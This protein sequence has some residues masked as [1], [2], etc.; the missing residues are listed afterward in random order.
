M[1][2]Q[3]EY[4]IKSLCLPKVGRKTAFKLFNNLSFNLSNDNDWIDFITEQSPLLRLPEYASNDFDMAL[5]KYDNIQSKSEKANIKCISFYD[6]DYP[7]L[8]KS[9]PDS[10]II[11][12]YVGDYSI[13]NTMPTLAIIGTRE[14]SEFGYQS[15]IR[16]SE[17]FTGFGFNIISGL[18][19]GCDTAG[20]KG[21][22]NKNGK[23][24]AVLAH[25]LDKIYPKDNKAL[26]QQIVDNGGLLISEY[27]VEQSPLANYF[28]ERDRI[29]AGLSLGIFVV[30]TDIKGGTMHTVKFATE[31][32]RIVSAL[33][34]PVD[35]LNH[36]KTN[37]N[38]FLIKEKKAIPIGN[39][40]DI[41]FLKNSLMER[42]NGLNTS[43]NTIQNNP[44]IVPPVNEKPIIKEN[45][46]K[47]SQPTLWD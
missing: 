46:N 26:A 3:T 28:V 37:G 47:P 39:P 12:N 15:G 41:E 21:C 2:I 27:F 24:T 31:A 32:N 9:I 6:S 25:G 45:K 8:L 14:P 33:N 36:S 5:K 23:T 11:L 10:P 22:L 7:V 1:K 40:N 35:K 13:V 43:T 18:A 16:I 4:I 30:E 38:Q 20:H 19:I 34:H 29:Q 44:S 42:F 17:L